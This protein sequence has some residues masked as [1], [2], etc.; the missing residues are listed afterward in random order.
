MVVINKTVT[1]DVH[2]RQFLMC[3]K[4]DKPED[5]GQCTKL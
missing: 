2:C 4:S 3:L 5:N 1:F